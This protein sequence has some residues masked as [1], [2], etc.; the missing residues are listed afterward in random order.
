MIL[1]A[2]ALVFQFGFAVSCSFVCSFGKAEPAWQQR[3]RNLVCTAWQPKRRSLHQNYSRRPLPRPLTKFVDPSS[4]WSVSGICNRVE[5][6]L[7]IV[8]P[9]SE[10]ARKETPGAQ[11]DGKV[12]AGRNRSEKS[13]CA[14]FWRDQRLSRSRHR[15]KAEKL[16]PLLNFVV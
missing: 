4:C 11:K 15:S 8:W 13:Q 7:Q 10:R 9:P 6:L 1:R 12:P 3:F 16:G 14:I 2:L 5:V